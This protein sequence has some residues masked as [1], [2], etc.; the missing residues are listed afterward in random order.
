MNLLKNMKEFGFCYAFRAYK[1][2]ILKKLTKKQKY[3]EKY[4]N[5][6]E[7]YLNKHY[8]YLVQNTEINDI[9]K[10]FQ[11]W[12]FWWQGEDQMPEIVKKCY[13]SI[14][15]NLAGH[16]INLITKENFKQFVTI[17]QYILDKVQSKTI[18]LTHFS[19]IL[20]AGLLSEYGGLWLDATIYLTDNIES[21]I[22]GRKFWTNKMSDKE[23]YKSFVS[24]GQWSGFF[25]AGAKGNPLFVGLKNILFKY[26]ETH[27]FLI[28]YLLIDYIISYL[29]HSSMQIN[30]MLKDVP[31]NND[32]LY[33]FANN[34][35]NAYSDEKFEKI[36]ADSKV[37]KLT[38]KFDQ[39]LTTKENTFYQKVVLAL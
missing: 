11:V 26:W 12:V 29:N 35:F 3:S 25:M 22:A 1:N 8:S 4:F 15:K 33:E 13:Q 9:E 30:Q 18:T 21:D 36:K 19:D 34:L 28:D 37:H 2:R 38:Y 31:I 27:N 6:I 5:N 39:S 7:S 16:K 23:K 14:Q 17:P 24:K 32:G 10:D 20:R